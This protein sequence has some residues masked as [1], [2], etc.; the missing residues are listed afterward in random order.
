MNPYSTQ[1]FPFY[2]PDGQNFPDRS[3]SSANSSWLVPTLFFSDIQYR[4]LFLDIVCSG[5]EALFCVLSVFPL[6]DI[7]TGYMI[8]PHK[9]TLFNIVVSIWSFFVVVLLLWLFLKSLLFLVC[10][11][12]TPQGIAL[13]QVEFV[14]PSFSQVY[15][16]F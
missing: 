4:V 8:D 9:H 14:W 13:I 11:E 15:T 16:F 1:L 12:I 5:F 10:T 2:S 7:I 6:F 3:L